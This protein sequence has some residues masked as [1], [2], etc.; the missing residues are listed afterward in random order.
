MYLIGK[1]GLSSNWG[2]SYNLHFP[3]RSYEWGNEAPNEFHLEKCDSFHYNLILYINFPNITQIIILLTSFFSKAINYP[4]YKFYFLK[5]FIIYVIHILVLLAPHKY[6]LLVQIWINFCLYLITV[7]LFNSC[8]YWATNDLRKTK[9]WT[10]IVR[11]SQTRVAVQHRGDSWT[12]IV[13]VSHIH[14]A[15]QHTGD[16]WRPRYRPS[17]KKNKVN[18]VWVISPHIIY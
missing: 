18:I 11:V 5:M 10:R 6:W 15:G 4:L 12:R 14:V 13:R 16:S 7:A 2:T 1:F 17:P 8:T 9:H 3:S